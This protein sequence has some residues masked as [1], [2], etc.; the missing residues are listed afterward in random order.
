MSEILIVDDE[1]DI[2]ELVAEVLHEEGYKICAR[3][4]AHDVIQYFEAGEVPLAVVLDIWLQGNEMDG[5]GILKYIKSQQPNVPVIMISGHGNIETAI[6]TIKLGAYDFIEK[7]FKAEKLLIVLNRALE[8]STLAEENRKLRSQYNLSAELIGNSKALQ[9]LKSA[10]LLA[11]PTNSRIVITGGAG[12]GKEVLAKF[13][14]ANSKRARK[15][16]V[17]LQ[18]SNFT[19]EQL[20]GEIFGIE[21]KGTKKKGFLENAD[22]GTLYIDELVE[23]PMATQ[24]KILKF[25]QTGVFQRIGSD[26]ELKVD[27]RVIAASSADLEEAIA[28]GTLNQSLYYRLNVVPL[29]MVP[30]DQ[31]KDDVKMI[32]EHFLKHFALSLN[33]PMK[34]I[35]NE[36][37]SIMCAYDWPGNIRQISNTVEWLYIMLP[38]LIE[39]ITPEM[40]PQELTLAINEKHKNLNPVN[41]DILAKELKS[42]RELFEKEYLCAQLNRFSGNISKTA[43]FIGMD[44]TALHRKIKSLGIKIAAN[45]EADAEQKAGN[46]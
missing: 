40:L 11:A 26:K 33:L 1:A 43:N 21:Q 14:H 12:S 2:R 19:P 31:R 41:N 29:K 36:T 34:K 44:R 42:A 18:A 7:P 3:S 13:I 25:L 35:S 16:F 30:I 4:S 27:V 10:A 28:N 23:L 8:V 37:L 45:S 5:I 6:N 32:V 9:N 15:S 24:S 38:S 46:S 39:E 17:C 22:Q 20:E